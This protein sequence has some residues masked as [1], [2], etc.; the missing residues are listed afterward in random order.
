[1]VDQ[2]KVRLAPVCRNIDEELGDLEARKIGDSFVRGDARLAH[3][4]DRNG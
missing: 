2:A 1:V 3:A 4:D